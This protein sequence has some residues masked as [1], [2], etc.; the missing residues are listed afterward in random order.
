MLAALGQSGLWPPIRSN[1]VR[2]GA[3]ALR[4]GV[5][6]QQPTSNDIPPVLSV[7]DGP[8]RTRAGTTGVTALAIQNGA[9]PL[10]GIYWGS[11]GGPVIGYNNGGAALSLDQRIGLPAAYTMGWTSNTIGTNALDTVMQRRAAGVIEQRAGTTAQAFE[12][13]NTWTSASNLEKLCFRA[14]AAA[15][16]E[17]GI[18]RGSVGGSLRGLSFGT[19]N[20]EASALTPY[21]TFN[22]GGN[23]CLGPNQ[24]PSSRLMIQQSGASTF[25]AVFDAAQNVISMNEGGS[26]GSGFWSEYAGSTFGTNCQFVGRRAKGT[27]AS[28]TTVIINDLTAAFVGQG[29]DGTAF[30]TGAQIVMA[31]DAA[32]SAGNV[33]QSIAFQTGSNAGGL[34]TRMTIA[35]TGL[36]SYPTT[37]TAG[38]TTGAQTINKLTGT[39]NF[40]A[41]ATSLVVTNSLVTTGSIVL[42]VI[43]TNDATA[44]IKNVV[45]AAGSFTINLNAAATAETSVGFIVI[46]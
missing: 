34:S 41:A 15:N 17:I 46:N 8:I 29:Y 14:V 11:N 42:C 10:F 21:A 33:P 6:S 13:A 16:Y 36:I 23:F 18:M 35:S 1:N 43:R 20:D 26:G 27:L 22:T 25:A 44:V 12:I 32:P 24:T 40:A 45:P 9:F 2:V 37:V 3:L 28:P 39:V 4:V 31:C 5:R 30:Q 19:Y 38:G 7:I